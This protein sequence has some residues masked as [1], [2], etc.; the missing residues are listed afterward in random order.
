MRKQ[1]SVAFAKEANNFLKDVNAQPN[2][3]LLIRA[4]AV[5]IVTS[6]IAK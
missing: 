6:R 1:C 5:L 2:A 3:Y 4:I